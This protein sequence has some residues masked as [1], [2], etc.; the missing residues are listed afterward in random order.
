[1]FI[2]VKIDDEMFTRLCRM[3]EQRA[4]DLAPAMKQVGEIVV[5]SVR[6]NFEAGGRPESWKPN[7]FSTM[8]G[9]A[10]GSAGHTLRGAPRMRAN[11][12]RRLSSKKV[13]VGQG[14]AGGLMGLI[15]YEVSSDG[16]LVGSDK[17]YGRIHQLGGTVPAMV[18]RPSFK[19][20]LY[21]PDA[22]HPVKKVNRPEIKIPARPYL[23]VQQSD[24]PAIHGALGRWLT[25]V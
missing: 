1:M 17:K 4:G 13:L 16:V 23:M 11:T 24:I 15:S 6:S 19:K 18:I 20:A 21:W 25:D 14:M 2:N 5:Q 22:L 8:W 9:L 3:V 12:E 10:R 7:A